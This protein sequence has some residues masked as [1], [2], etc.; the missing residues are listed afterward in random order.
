ML[1]FLN[2]SSFVTGVYKPLL[3]HEQVKYE[4]KFIALKLKKALEG[5]NH[6]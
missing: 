4:T 1:Y 2:N 6:E 5:K 3:L